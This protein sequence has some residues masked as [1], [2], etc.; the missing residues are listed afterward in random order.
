MR[1]IGSAVFCLLTAL[2]LL[3]SC[4]KETVVAN[5]E[6]IPLPNS[7]EKK[8]GI[9]FVMD[10]STVITYPAGNE[11][12]KRTAEF[13]SEYLKLSTGMALTVSDEEASK[14][15][16]SLK[17]DYPNDNKEAYNL[18]VDTE[19]IT[20]N[21]ASEAGTFYGVQTLRKSIA[22]DSDGKIISL[23]PVEI[24]DYPRFGYRGMHQDVS[25]H[26]FSVEFV[27]K[28]IDILALHN[29][30][31]LHWHL[32]DDQGW[33]IEIKKY[34]ELTKIGSQRKH[35]VIGK[36]T[37]EYD[38]T[39]HGG[40]YTQE[41]IKDVVKY[42]E[43]R[44]ITVIP[45]IDMPGHMLAA[46]ATYPE[47]G[48]TGG[49][50]EVE[51]T[52]GVFEDVLCAGNEKTYEFVENVLAEVIELFP[53]HYIHIGGDE[54]PKTKW[55][56]CPK[57]QAK[58]KQEGLKAD[59][60]HSKEDALQS[61]F[62]SR[63]E[64]YV[65]SKGREIIGWDEILEGG[66]APNATVM[67]WRGMEGGIAAAKEKHNAIMVPTSY[68]YFDYY[69]SK[70][71]KGEPFGI[72]GFVPVEKVYSLEPVPAELNDEEKKYI[73][74]TQ[75]N[76][77]AEYISTPEHAEYMLLPRLAALSEVQ[78]MQ[79]EKK[80]YE[81][82]LTRFGQLAVAYDVL[83]YNYAKHIFDIR[84]EIT[85]DAEKGSVNIVLKTI[86]NAS[87]YYTTD[88][89]EPTEKSTQYTAPIDLKESVTLKAMAVYPDRK[90]NVYSQ[91][92]VFSK[93]TL[94]PVKLTTPPTKNYTYGGAAALVDGI[95]GGEVYNDGT[96]IGFKGKNIDAVIDLGEETDISSV[97]VGTFVAV[98]DWI[99]GA[100][101]LW[102]A[103]SKDGVFYD[104]VAENTF[105]ES[106][107]GFPAQR[108]NVEAKFDTKKAR[109]V[110]II[111]SGPQ[112]VPDWHPGKG[113][114]P[115]LFIDEIQI[116]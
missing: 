103:V 12:L 105:F 31:R 74:G 108:V 18:V 39:P 19:Q 112:K 1:K 52:W 9:P 68:C 106:P 35:T 3:S 80:N 2:L 91:S 28:Y 94:K 49:P 62:I 111:I 110:Q 57:C 29:V 81:Q 36:N 26:F 46:L 21:G 43:E 86:N 96:W 24:I 33:R 78:W 41:E 56:E 73:I 99:F 107:Q 114:Q 77:W 83:G 48:C 22:A 30:N 50:Y 61:Y 34:P 115:F 47:L 71:T 97:K 4:S 38:G 15:Y 64:K 92:F 65:N 16:I 102:V 87:V 113:Q 63:V 59:T 53:S 109:Y 116:Q 8:E 6:V 7:I 76:L 42:A 69:Q 79:P 51:P 60:K 82:F 54:C 75:A 44:F 45:E 98:N 5:Y 13:L 72:G 100:T 37:G 70:D 55:K 23:P 88:G 20:I 10:N 58:I 101:S 95:R 14:N 85:S 27:K 84:P 11:K 17:A 32:T 67:S 93:A 25:R 104:K 40:F 89:T 90:S 66:L